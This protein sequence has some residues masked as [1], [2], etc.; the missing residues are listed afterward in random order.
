MA[1]LTIA[2]YLKFANLQM[3]AEAF[4]RDEQTGILATTPQDIARALE[5]GNNRSLLFTETQATAFAA[6]WEVLDQRANTG[7][8]FSGTLFRNKANPNELVLSFRSSEFIDDFARDNKATNEFEIAQGGFALGQIADMEAWYAELLTK[9]DAN[10]QPMLAGKTYSV[11]GYSLGAHL[12]TVFNQLRQVEIQ[13]GPP[14]ANLADV[15][16]FNGA[17][18]GQ[19][20]NGSL[21]GM[22]QRFQSLRNQAAS[23]DGLRNL[24]QTDTG[25][26]AYRD[27][28][29]AINANNG[30]VTSTMRDTAATAFG[31]NF[32]DKPLLKADSDLLLLAI[33]RAL[34]VWQAAN[35]APNLNSGKGVRVI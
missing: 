25:L 21:A 26:T 32:L 18:I 9:F 11:T 17:G 1:A 28:R 12:A 31:T 34:T 13:Q 15:I 19:I 27:L 14:R 10:G 6:Q 8:G 3:A 30:V 35:D 20:D 5:R 4:I 24:F 16:T 2:D 23:A 29:S 33:D 22:V 7:T